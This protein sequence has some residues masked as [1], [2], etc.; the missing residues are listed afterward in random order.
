[1]S[2]RGYVFTAIMVAMLVLGARAFAGPLVEPKSGNAEAQKLIDQAWTLDHTDSSAQIYKQCSSL[3]EQAAKLDPNNQDMQSELSRYLWEYA[4]RMP[5]ETKDQQKFLVGIY[6]KGLVA[7]EQSVKLKETPAG[8][9]WL[10]V[11]KSA[12]LEFSS[13]VEQAAG[14]PTIIRNSN[15][16]RDHEPSYYFGANGRLL[17]EILTRVPKIVVRMVGW[18]PQDSL[19]RITTAIKEEPKYFDNYLYKARFL[20]VYYENKDEALKI[21]DY[22]LKQDSNAMPSEVV[23]NKSSQRDARELWKKI[24]GKEYPNK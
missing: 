18:N 21:L 2:K 13:I 20:Y 6:T 8:H 14:F 9:Y 12:S 11:N 10:A 7:A 4:N 5:K 15:W 1:M 3:L 16:V 22:E 17:T 23:A 24:T 19:D